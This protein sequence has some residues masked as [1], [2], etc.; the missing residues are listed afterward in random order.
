MNPLIINTKV[1]SF[2]LTNKSS[3]F[4]HI[5][6]ET[7]NVGHSLTFCFDKTLQEQLQLFLLMGKSM[8]LDG[9]QHLFLNKDCKVDSI[10]SLS[11]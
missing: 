8:N 7:A 11:I 5:R 9:G 4:R 3:Q 6:S 2:T 10:N 1:L